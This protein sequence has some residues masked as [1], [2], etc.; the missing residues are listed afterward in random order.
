MQTERTGGDQG[1]SK[2]F[3]LALQS[4]QQSAVMLLRLVSE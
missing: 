3:W 1:S 4:E 2:Q